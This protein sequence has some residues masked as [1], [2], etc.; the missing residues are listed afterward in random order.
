MYP[1]LAVAEVLT[2][3][4]Q[5]EHKLSF[6]GSMGGGGFE[7]RIVEQSNLPFVG[8]GAVFAGPIVGVNPLRAVWS[9]L[10]MM[11]GTIQAALL[12]RR[13]KPQSLLLTGGWANVPLALAA[14]LLRVPILVYLPD[15]E[16]GRTIQLVA[17]F[18]SRVATTVDE[19]ARYFR[20]GQSVT[21]GYPL[22][23]SVTESTRQAALA[24]FRLDPARRTLLVFGGSRGARSINLALMRI[25]PDLLKADLQVLHVTGELDWPRVQAE[26]A[27]LPDARGYQAFPYLHADMGLAFAAAD[28]VVCRSG[29]STL[30]EL[31]LFGLASIL[32]PYPYAWRYQRTNADYLADRGAAIR[33][34]DEAMEQ[35][36]LPAILGLHQ[37]PQG[38]EAMQESARALARG[39]GAACIGQLLQDLAGGRT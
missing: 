39:D 1:A 16:P 35:D 33:M 28:M 24:H 19:S 23:R 31:P 21:T 8:Y 20:A 17:R 29:A 10:L 30:G 34:D 15:I 26:M 2:S 37:H 32:V 27:A 9:V 3:P 18:A 14:R 38:L 36:L 7:K 5:D 6:V 11:A 25:L 13:Y 4:G 22:R 12:L